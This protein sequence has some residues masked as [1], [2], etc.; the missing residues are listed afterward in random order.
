MALHLSVESDIGS[1]VAVCEFFESETAISYS[2]ALA[3]ADLK[4][5]GLTF[6]LPEVVN[7][8]RCRFRTPQIPVERVA[9]PI[10]T[11]QTR[12]DR[13]EFIRTRDSSRLSLGRLK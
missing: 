6:Q 10:A 8:R 11:L 1:C 12:V 7:S 2:S 3:A 4:F 9:F 13:C 5:L